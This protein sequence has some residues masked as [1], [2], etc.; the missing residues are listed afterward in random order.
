M[1]DINAAL[2]EPGAEVILEYRRVL[3]NNFIGLENKLFLEINGE[4]ADASINLLTDS[5]LLLEIVFQVL[6][7]PVLEITRYPLL[8]HIF[9]DAE[10]FCLHLHILLGD[11]HVD[12]SDDIDLF[13]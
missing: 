9:R 13:R 2:E 7:H 5:R 1:D 11:V 12:I 10:K 8:S 6:L 4:Q 3:E